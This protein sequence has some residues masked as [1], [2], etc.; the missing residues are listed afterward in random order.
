MVFEPEPTNLS[1][2]QYPKQQTK[3]AQSDSQGINQYILSGET[4][5]SGKISRLL[6]QSC[7]VLCGPV[8]FKIPF[9]YP[10]AGHLGSLRA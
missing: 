4:T 3:F 7:V 8:K 6:W 9:C 5:D 10:V 1:P 2:H